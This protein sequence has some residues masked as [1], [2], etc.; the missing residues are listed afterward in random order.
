MVTKILLASYDK[1][2]LVPVIIGGF[3]AIDRKIFS[4]TAILLIFIMVLNSFLKSIF[5]VPLTQ[6]QILRFIHFQ[7]G[8]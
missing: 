2:V 7:V 4:H 1:V 3:L 6:I 5:Q 8:I